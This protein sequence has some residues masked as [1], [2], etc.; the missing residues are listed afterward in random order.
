MAADPREFMPRPGAPPSAGRR[1][2]VPLRHQRG[3]VLF[4]RL[5]GDHGQHY[6]L[7]LPR[8]GSVNARVLVSVHG[9]SRNARE[10]AEEFARLAERHGVV[11]VAPLFSADRFPGYQR[12]GRRADRVLE[13]ILAEVGRLTGA[14]TRRVYLFGFSGGGQFVHRY[15]MANPRRVRAYVLGAPGWYTFPDPEQRYPRGIAPDDSRTGPRFEPE[16][17]LRVPATVVVG[18]H[19]GERDPSLRADPRIDRQ[20]GLNR[21]E[22]GRRWVQAMNLAARAR[23]LVAPF[24]FELLPGAGHSFAQSAADRGLK[25]RVFRALFGKNGGG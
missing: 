13:S 25:E 23:G 20:Q 17:F 19:D 1:G 24:R 21:I 6:F 8:S 10:H 7:Y 3:R 15:A 18:E 14:F 4:R 22:R 5:A 12:L 2:E 16:E 11:L 9:I